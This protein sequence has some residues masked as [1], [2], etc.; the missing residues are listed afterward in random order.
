MKVLSNQL[1]KRKQAFLRS[2]SPKQPSNSCEPELHIMADA[3]CL[4]YGL[5]L[6]VVLV[7]KSEGT[8]LACANCQAGCMSALVLCYEAA[9]A[10]F[11][12]GTARAP[13]AILACNAGYGAC[14]AA[15][16]S[17]RVAPISWR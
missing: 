9:G 12:T 11:G 15:C 3:R 7:S 17:V 10:I 2:L 1:A 4:T 16:T 5:L 8:L 6:I 14:Y 13:A